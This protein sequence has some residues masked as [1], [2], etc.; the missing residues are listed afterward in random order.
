MPEH[1][2]QSLLRALL[3]GLDVLARHAE[4]LEHDEGGELP[5][6]RGDDLGRPWCSRS[7]TKRRTRSRTNGSIAATATRGER[8]IRIRPR[9]G[10]HGRIDVR[11]RRDRAELPL[12]RARL[13]PRGTGARGGRARSPPRTCRTH[14]APV[15]SRRAGARPSSRGRRTRRRADF[16]P[17]RETSDTDRRGTQARTG[18]MWSSEPAGGA[19]CSAPDDRQETDGRSDWEQIDDGDVVWR[20]DR[21]FLAVELDLHLGPGLPRHP[22]RAGRAPR[23]GLLLDRR[24]A[25]RRGRGD[26]GLRA[27]RHART[28]S[29]SSTTAEADDGGIFSDDTG[30]TPG[31]STTRASS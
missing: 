12:G 1:P 9:P 20:F 18:R 28:P 10:V 25:R 8:E 11:Q 29:A 19:H 14:E 21:D 30:R 2:Q 31:S 7:E 16:R 13:R 6:Q 5:R 26:A 4:D 23:P 3:D 17:G 22:R 15:D 27:R 24:R